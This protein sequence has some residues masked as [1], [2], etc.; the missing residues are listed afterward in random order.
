MTKSSLKFRK[1]Y[2]IAAAAKPGFGPLGPVTAELDSED[3]EKK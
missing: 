3:I 1:N 2:T